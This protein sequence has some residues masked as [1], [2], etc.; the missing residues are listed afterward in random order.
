MSGEWRMIGTGQEELLRRML[1]P[2]EGLPGG[3]QFVSAA[4]AGPAVE[5]RYRLGM[6]EALVRLV[7]PDAAREDALKT[8]NFAIDDAAA[9]PSDLLQALE[10]SML[11]RERRIHWGESRA[12]SEH[13][14]DPEWCALQAGVK[15]A[16]RVSVSPEDA[17]AVEQRHRA[18]GASVVRAEQETMVGGRTAVLLYIA[19]DEVTAEQV[20][21]I[22][23]PIVT[24]ALDQAQER[25]LIEELGTALGYP[26][27][28][29]KAFARRP[30]PGLVSFVRSFISRRSGSKDYQGARDAWVATPAPR[31]NPFLKCLRR[32]LIAF[33]PCRYD[34]EEALEHADRVATACAAVDP[35]WLGETERRLAEPVVIAANGA[36]AQVTLERRIEP[37]RIIDARALCAPGQEPNAE[38][39]QLATDVMGAE[40]RDDGLLTGRGISKCL[41]VDFG[42]AAS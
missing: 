21:E 32:S 22:E 3:W 23:R 5:A 16:L 28:C 36:T 20:R 24:Q 2:P 9:L 40:V 27:C 35:L 15:P 14:V 37:M 29:V 6:D 1:D 31:L 34:C 7:H 19:K 4:I 42:K 41:L 26:S 38:Q 18:L 11:A 12:K 30:R 8:S 25:Q 17:A 10:V 13:R 33:E 39:T